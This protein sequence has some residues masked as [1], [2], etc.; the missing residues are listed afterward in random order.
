[1]ACTNINTYTDRKI[2][3]CKAPYYC[4]SCIKKSIPFS[5]V[6]DDSFKEK[7]SRQK[8]MSHGTKK[9]MSHTEKKCLT[10]KENFS[11]QSKE[12]VKHNSD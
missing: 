10:P 11:Q 4:K 1:M 9:R 12:K 6:T 5:E 8:T 7:A 2:K 3:K